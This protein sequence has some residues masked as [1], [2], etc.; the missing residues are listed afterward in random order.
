MHEN[1]IGV[2][3][4]VVYNHTH[5]EDSW[6]QR[7]VPG[8]YYRYQEDGSLSNGSACGNDIAAGRSMVDNYIADS[9]MYW[10]KEYHI[11]GF[12]FD[13]MGL[14]TV[15]LMN[16]IRRELDAEFG[17]GKKMMYG[18]PW[19]AADSPMEKGTRAAQKGNAGFLDDGVGIFC[20]D[21]RDVIPGDGAWLCQWR[22]RPGDCHPPGGDRMEGRR[23]LL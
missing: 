10:A 13:L 22:H 23:G 12:R 2:I 5:Q 21:T 20:D 6:L 17:P 14:L 18:E 3:M 11:D 9:V 1:G 4:D 8:Y 19:S 15:E 16:R 7:M